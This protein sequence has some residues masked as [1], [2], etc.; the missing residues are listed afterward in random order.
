MRITFDA[1]RAFNNKTGLGNYSRSVIKSV[2]SILKKDQFFLATPK[3]N[4]DIFN[5]KQPNIKILQ[6]SIFQNHY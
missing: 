3:V 2:S 1:K 4:I 5:I 6:P